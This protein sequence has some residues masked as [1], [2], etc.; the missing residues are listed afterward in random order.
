MALRPL[1]IFHEHE[2]IKVKGS[3]SH[4]HVVMPGVHVSLRS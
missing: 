4:A 2:A 1:R 3:G